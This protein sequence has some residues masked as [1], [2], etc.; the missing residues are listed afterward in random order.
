[1]FPNVNKLSGL[2]RSLIN[3]NDVFLSNSKFEIK[4]YAAIKNG[5]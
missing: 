5:I 2:L 4:E 3:K 1:M